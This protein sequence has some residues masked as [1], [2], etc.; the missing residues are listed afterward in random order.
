MK[1]LVFLPF[2][3]DNVYEHANCLS[4]GATSS[5]CSQTLRYYWGNQWNRVGVTKTF[6]LAE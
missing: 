2:I 3:S 5:Y 6:N 4:A 1:L